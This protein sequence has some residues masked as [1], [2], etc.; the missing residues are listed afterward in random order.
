[1]K[2]FLAVLVVVALIGFGL[3]RFWP[4]GQSPELARTIAMRLEYIVMGG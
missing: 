1:M 4:R 3:W 2:K